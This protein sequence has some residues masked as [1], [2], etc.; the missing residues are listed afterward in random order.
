MP[1]LLSVTFI[2]QYGSYNAGEIA[3]FP[4]AQAQRL[5]REKAAVP[6]QSAVVTVAA[7]EEEPAPA[8]AHRVSRHSAA[9]KGGH[10]A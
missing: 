1:D 10:G 6:T 5:F 3:A 8:K 4:E 2:R 9:K 7:V